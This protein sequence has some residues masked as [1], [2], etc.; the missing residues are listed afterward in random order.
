MLW[1]T[2]HEEKQ[3]VAWGLPQELADDNIC[4]LTH[5]FRDMEGKIEN[6]GKEE[7]STGFINKL[8]TQNQRE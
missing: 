3:E 1:E 6:L 2:L 8:K 4:L 5:I 7:K